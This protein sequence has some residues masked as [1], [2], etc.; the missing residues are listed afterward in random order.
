[1]ALTAGVGRAARAGILFRDIEAI[2]KAGRVT[3]FFLDKTGTLT[4]GRP[5]LVDLALS[6][7]VSRD[8]LIEDAA[9]AERGSEHPLAKAI[10]CLRVDTDRAGLSMPEGVSRA[11]PGNG[12]EWHDRNGTSILVG[13]RRYLLSLGVGVPEIETHHTS[14]HVA[15]NGQWRGCLM[16]SDIP[17]PR[18]SQTVEALRRSGAEIAM[19]TGDQIDVARRVAQS[20]G[21]S[22]DQV[23]AEQQ[24]E[25]KS[26]RIL[27][28]QA[29]G[30]TVAFVGDGLND[31]PALAAADL[32]IAVGGASASSVAAASIVLVDQGIERLEAALVAARV[33]A[34]AMRQ[35]L[36]GAVIYNLL[37]VPL[38][39]A[40]FVAPAMAAGLMIASSL[41]V[42]L[43]SARLAWAQPAP[44]VGNRRKTSLAAQGARLVDSTIQPSSPAT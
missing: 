34:R 22:R 10:Q 9:I 43:N 21:I 14:V 36:G 33:T 6:G 38:A 18:A 30:S 25:V 4:E 31:A 28:T 35:N 32:G 39:A 29:T 41:S 17:R 44:G 8:E 26:A 16:F 12:V 1:L 11:V 19:L 15:R 27:A 40:G 13:S 7:R 5:Q 2:E 42:T 20:V 37:A 3:L 23:Y 24:P